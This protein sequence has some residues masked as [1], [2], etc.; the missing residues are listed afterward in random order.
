[1]SLLHEVLV[2]PLLY[3]TATKQTS[4]SGGTLKKLLNHIKAEPYKDLI[5]ALMDLGAVEKV[6]SAFMPAFKAGRM[7]A[8]GMMYLHGS[9]NLGGTIS[10]RLSSSDPNLQ[11]LPAGS[12]YGKLVKS[13][14]CA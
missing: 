4:T 10:G 11:N 6:I 3:G 9:F 12:T 14:F 13:L 5:Q 1:A 2:L 8:D 7:K